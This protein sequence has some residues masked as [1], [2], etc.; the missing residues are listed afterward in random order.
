MRAL[1]TFKWN[2]TFSNGLLEMIVTV[3]AKNSTEARAEAEKTLANDHSNN[4]KITKV[5]RVT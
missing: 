3:R 5:R 1:N 4:F 2:I